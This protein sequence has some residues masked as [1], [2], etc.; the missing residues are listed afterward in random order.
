MP[1]RTRKSLA[2]AI[3]IYSIA[4]LLGVAV[5]VLNLQGARAHAVSAANHCT[6]YA[7]NIT[8]DYNCALSGTMSGGGGYYSTPHTGLRDQNLI[9]LAASRNWWVWYDGGNYGY[10][11]GIGTYGS[12]YGSSGFAYALCQISGSSVSG[13]C[14]TYWHD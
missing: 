13:H 1:L 14:T 7:P 11:S 5:A 6:R 12:I 2:K 8:Q 4:V 10:A 3:A 9:S